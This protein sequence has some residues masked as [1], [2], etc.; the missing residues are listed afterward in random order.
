MEGI[1]LILITTHMRFIHIKTSVCFSCHD[2]DVSQEI[3]K[4]VAV[5]SSPH[6]DRISAAHEL[7]QSVQRA[8]ETL[9]LQITNNAEWEWYK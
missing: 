9:D 2:K 6:Q 7:T 5:L 1:A 3:G 8:M 4:Q